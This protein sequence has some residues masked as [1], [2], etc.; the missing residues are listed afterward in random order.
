MCGIINHYK[1][2][3]ELINQCFANIKHLG[4]KIKDK[5][6]DSS[7]LS[8]LKDRTKANF[9][10]VMRLRLTDS[11]PVK[12]SDRSKLNVDLM[13]LATKDQISQV[14]HCQAHQS[15]KHPNYQFIWASNY[16]NVTAGRFKENNTWQVNPHNGYSWNYRDY[17]PS[18]AQIWHVHLKQRPRAKKQL[19]GSKLIL[20]THLQQIPTYKVI[21]DGLFSTHSPINVL[22]HF[23]GK[24]VATNSEK[25]TV[26]AYTIH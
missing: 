18:L 16:Q 21:E 1:E 24:V 14:L 26:E 17:Q 25:K 15:T 3:K 12:Y 5:K 20:V 13:Q 6:A 8:I 11:N 4:Q 9:F 10:S 7:T 22:T 19:V 2:H 23:Q